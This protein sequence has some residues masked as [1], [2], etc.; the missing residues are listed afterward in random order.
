MFLRKA[1]HHLWEQIPS[2]TLQPTPIS[3]R[4]VATMLALGPGFWWILASKAWQN[5]IH[6]Y[7]VYID[8]SQT[9][10]DYRPMGRQNVA[11]PFVQTSLWFSLNVLNRPYIYFRPLSSHYMHDVKNHAYYLLLRN[12]LGACSNSSATSPI[13][14]VV[15]HNLSPGCPGQESSLSFGS[16]RWPVYE[17]LEPPGQEASANRILMVAWCAAVGFDSLMQISP[18]R[19]LI[20]NVTC[21]L[22]LHRKAT[23]S[24]GALITQLAMSCTWTLKDSVSKCPFLARLHSTGN[25]RSRL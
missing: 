21:S 25:S 13:R 1:Y 2:K 9:V 23:V 8:I 7:D 12:H 18:N 19:Q 3:A 11:I 5:H 10:V 16:W 24:L 22:A 17:N 14:S 6:V 15:F 20:N 4:V